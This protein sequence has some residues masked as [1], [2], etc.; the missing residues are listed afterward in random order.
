MSSWSWSTSCRARDHVD[1]GAGQAHDLPATDLRGL[2]RFVAA[3]DLD[4][5]VGHHQL[6]HPAARRKA[7]GLQQ[8]IERDVLAAQ[9]EADLCHVSP[10]SLAINAYE[11]RRTCGSCAQVLI[12]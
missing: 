12:T 8:R 6:G 1:A 9:L 3:V 4:V 2:A 5:A 10:N 7:R 11:T